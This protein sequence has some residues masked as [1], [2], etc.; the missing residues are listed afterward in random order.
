HRWSHADAI[1]V[2]ARR[3]AETVGLDWGGGVYVN[4]VFTLMWLVDACW[5]WITRARY[6]NRPAWMNGAVYGFLVVIAFNATVVFATGPTRW[7][8]VAACLLL[9]TGPLLRRLLPTFA[10]FP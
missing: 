9:A 8:G 2:T 7:L 1:E 6:E 10:I 4:Y 5:W 3:T